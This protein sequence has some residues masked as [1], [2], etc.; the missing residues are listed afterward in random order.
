M[1]PPLCQGCPLEQTGEGYAYGDFPDD[2]KT[3]LIGEALGQEEVYQKRPFVGGAGR[4]LNYLLGR[5]GVYRSRLAVTNAVRCRPPQNRTPIPNEIEECMRRHHTLDELPRFNLIVPLGNTALYAITGRDKISKWRGSIF[6]VS[7]GVPPRPCKV[8][9]TFHPAALMRQQ[10]L[11]PICIADFQKIPQEEWT[12]E[13]MS[14]K[15]V[16]E[17]DSHSGHVHTYLDAEAF[18]FDVETNMALDPS[19]TSI[20]VLGLCKEEGTAHV[21]SKLHTDPLIRGKVVELFA[22]PSLKIGHNI[23]FDIR[24]M[25]ANGVPVAKPW[26][27]T[28]IAHHLV[29]SDVP[30]DLAFASSLYTRIPYWKDMIRTDLKLYNATDVDATF[31]LYKA[32][33]PRLKADGLESTFQLSMDVLP[34][35]MAMHETG[36]RV[37]LNVQTK[38]RI[39]LSRVVARKEQELS[40]LVCDPTFNWRSP[41]QLAT[42]LYTKLKF[43]PI[44]NKHT[45]GLTTDEDALKAL[46]E[47][48]SDP[49]SAQVLKLLLDL[50]GADKLLTTYFEVPVGTTGRVHTDFL[51]HGTSTGRLSSRHP[52][53]QNVPK[54]EARSIY[55]PAEGNTFTQADY[56]QIE[57]RISAILAHE[58]DLIAAF[59]QGKDVHRETASKVY[60]VAPSEVTELQR[61]RAKFIVFGLMYGRGAHSIAKEYK[62]TL[63]EATRFIDEYSRQFPNIWN[64]RAECLRLAQREGYLVN[65]FGRR[66]YFYGPSI[67]TKVY[68]FIPS[69]AAADVLLKALVQLHNDLPHGARLVLT[70]HDQVLIEHPLSA[71]RAVE[72]CLHDI[73]EAPVPELA[74]HIIPIAISTGSNWGLC[75]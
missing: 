51:I 42:L 75:K 72:E 8:L 23:S 12:P 20:T 64:W 54:G 57:L 30:N 9:P 17:L 4:T 65:P 26:F 68:N 6:T 10:E 3:I 25:E 50:R 16:Y 19:P 45:Q 47:R 66:R 70:V 58:T 33:A 36:V 59:K 5:S 29:L 41:K 69:S 73:M 46:A 32:L 11:I 7:L 43:P 74:N 28:M 56:N 35:L 53:L 24:H 34:A 44:Y 55:V 39:G 2:A 62:M 49:A 18:S 71:Q 61:F 52:N 31:R 1:K 48:P 15:Q 37:D 13:Y 27:D 21:T 40:A 14:P 60:H 63:S 67:A 38:Y 22:G